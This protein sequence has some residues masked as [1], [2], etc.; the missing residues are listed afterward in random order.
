MRIVQTTSRVYFFFPYQYTV[1]AVYGSDGR[2][3]CKDPSCIYTGNDIGPHNCHRIYIYA[4]GLLCIIHNAFR[5]V[6]IL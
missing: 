2:L 6:L 5:Y 1:I 4:L 3:L